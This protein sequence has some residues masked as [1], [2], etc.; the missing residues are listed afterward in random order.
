MN[1]RI[2]FATLVLFAFAPAASAQY[3]F[4]PIDA[5]INSTISGNAI[6]GYANF[7]GLDFG[8]YPTSPTINVVSGSFITGELSAYNSSTV[9]VSGGVTGYL[10]TQTNSTANVSGGLITRSL[11]AYNSSVVN[12]SGGIINNGLY[13]FNSS[14]V[15]I[16]GGVIN[17]YL[18]AN[19]GTINVSGGTI[20]SGLYSNNGGTLNVSG[21]ALTDLIAYGD[22]TI[23]IFGTGLTSALINPSARGAYSEYALSGA[24]SSGDSLSGIEVFV[25][26]GTGAQFSL[27]NTTV[28][29]EPGSFALLVGLSTVGASVLRKRRKG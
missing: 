7:E 20:N 18:R 24:L 13:A 14:V 6:V 12:V 21:G 28:T 5:T 29:P 22:G 27:I 3:I 19:S 8:S 17:Y 11:T 2:P 1:F 15:N 23:N 26:N 25:Q 4:F 10:T 16:S 9:N